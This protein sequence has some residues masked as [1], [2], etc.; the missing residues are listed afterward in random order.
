MGR[1]ARAT[2]SNLK[3]IFALMNK[4]LLPLLLCCS[5]FGACTNDSQNKPAAT[6][7]D[8]DAARTFINAALKGNWKEARLLVVQDSTNMQL[9]D[10]LES[11]YRLHMSR[12]DKSGYRDASITL[13]DS[14]PLSD[15]LT[16]VNYSNSFKKKRDSVKVVNAGG[17]W[18]VDLKYSFPQTDPSQNGQ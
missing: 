14:R 1:P 16:I 7:G 11:N 5:L 12:E 18:L 8:L 4:R 3:T 2:G 6:E 13:Y 15:S 9:V 17:Q 10:M